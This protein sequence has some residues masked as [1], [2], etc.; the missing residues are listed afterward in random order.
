MKGPSGLSFLRQSLHHLPRLVVCQMASRTQ[1]DKILRP[2]I[3]LDVVDVCHRQRPL[4]RVEL[5]AWKTTLQTALLALPAR[6]I[7]DCVCD[8][9]PILWIFGSVHR[10]GNNPMQRSRVSG[11]FAVEALSTRPVD[12]KRSSYLK[13]P[14]AESNRN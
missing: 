6:L 9:N 13:L 10:H 7:F 5:L 12:W 14:L 8:L 4:V 1:R 3:H 11:V 2:A